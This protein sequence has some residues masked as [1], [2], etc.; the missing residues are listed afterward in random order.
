[1]ARTILAALAAAAILSGC[2]EASS[3]NTGRIGNPAV[4]DRIE[5]LTDCNA[6]YQEAN[7]ALDN[8]ERY[9]AGDDRRD[10]P[11]AYATAALDRM[12]AIGCSD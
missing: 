3:G 12:R 7:T 11:F 8:V 2:T 4:Y 6:L 9:P 5:R 1:M 10:I